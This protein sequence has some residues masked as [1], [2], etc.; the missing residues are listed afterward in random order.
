MNETSYV[1]G[2][3]WSPRFGGYANASIPLARL[4]LSSNGLAIE[5]S[6]RFVAWYVP[7]WT[8]PWR[9]VERAE[10]VGRMPVFTTGVRIFVHG[11]TRPF[12]FWTVHPDD[13]LDALK[14]WGVPVDHAYH[15]INWLWGS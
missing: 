2:I 9:D 11:K 7:D 14:S 10:R 15:R 12:T 8:F 1:G 13:V 3:R 6:N 4:R 5:P